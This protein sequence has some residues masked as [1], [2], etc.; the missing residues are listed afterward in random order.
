MSSRF[1]P[2]QLDTEYCLTGKEK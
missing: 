1:S 2:Q